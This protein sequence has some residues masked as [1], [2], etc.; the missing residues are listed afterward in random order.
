MA[1]FE[2]LLEEVGL[3]KYDVTGLDIIRTPCGP[4]GVTAVQEEEAMHPNPSSRSVVDIL[5]HEKA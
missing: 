5:H 2:E 4:R 3:D 1:G